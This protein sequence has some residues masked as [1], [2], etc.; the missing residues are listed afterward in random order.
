MIARLFASVSM[1]ALVIAGMA[2]TL[3]LAA[4]CSS[5]D[6]NTKSSSSALSSC[7]SLC[8]VEAKGEGCTAKAGDLCRQLCDGIAG[9]FEGDCAAKAD[10]YYKCGATQ[11][12]KCQ[13]DLA[14]STDQGCKAELDAYNAACF[15]KK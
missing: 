7:K 1:R 10:T 15:T 6:D 11:K 14:F 8:D 5:D 3:T 13:G 12:Y 4:G 2:A 9:S